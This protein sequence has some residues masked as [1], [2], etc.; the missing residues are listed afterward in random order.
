MKETH[1]KDLIRIICVLQLNLEKNEKETFE[2][3]LSRTRSVSHVRN[4]S[5]KTYVD[6][7]RLTKETYRR[8][9]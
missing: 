2:R 5:K 8:D 4:I 6:E 9:L 1:K 7:K 3:D